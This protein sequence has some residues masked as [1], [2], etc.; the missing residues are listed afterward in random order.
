VPDTLL[1]V[2]PLP[3][4]SPTARVLTVTPEQLKLDSIDLHAASACD[5]VHLVQITSSTQ[6]LSLQQAYTVGTEP[7]IKGRAQTVSGVGSGLLTAKFII[8]GMQP[9][10]LTLYPGTNTVLV[11][12]GLVLGIPTIADV[13][14]SSTIQCK[15]LKSNIIL[16]LAEREAVAGVNLAGKFT[17]QQKGTILSDVLA[18]ELTEPSARTGKASAA[19][20]GDTSSFNSAAISLL[21]LFISFIISCK[22]FIY[23][24]LLIVFI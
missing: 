4:T 14:H 15:Q 10:I 20:H 23:F 16:G 12:T 2:H 21:K 11:W 19:V 7:L 22:F 13:Q 9:T 1:A 17:I 5:L 8:N 6:T 3:D 18:H 24:L